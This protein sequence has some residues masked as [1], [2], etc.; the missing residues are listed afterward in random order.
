MINVLDSGQ[1]EYKK[2]NSGKTRQV[3]Y[4]VLE[5]AE[6]GEMVDYVNAKNGFGLDLTR[7][8]FEQLID[9]VSYCHNNGTVH[10]DLK[11]ENILFD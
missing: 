6:G 11:L 2:I 10:R 7:A 5:L 4:I 9:V 3:Y 1:N 8:Y